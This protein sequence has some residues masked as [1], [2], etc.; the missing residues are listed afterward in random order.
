MC[1]KNKVERFRIRTLNNYEKDRW[2]M[3]NEICQM[4]STFDTIVDSLERD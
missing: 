3:E 2:I 1:S 4:T